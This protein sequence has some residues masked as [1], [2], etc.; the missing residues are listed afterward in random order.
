MKFTFELTKDEANFIVQVLGELPYK[1]SF[2][3]IDNLRNQFMSQSQEQLSTNEDK[4]SVK[5]D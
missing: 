3:L 1:S 5:E 4:G 2:K